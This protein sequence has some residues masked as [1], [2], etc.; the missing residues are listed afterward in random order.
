[1]KGQSAINVNPWSLLLAL[2]EAPCSVV[3]TDAGGRV[4]YVNERFVENSGYS[5][6]DV[7]GRKPG[8]VLR[9]GQTPP[10]TY[11][12]MWDT[13]KG[14]RVWH[15]D[16]YNRTKHGETRIERA[17]IIPMVENGCTSNYLSIQHD[18]GQFMADQQKLELYEALFQNT[19]IGILVTDHG[20]RILAINPAFTEITGYAQAEVQG[21]TPAML[22]SGMMPPEFYRSL[23]ASLSQTGSWAGEIINR[24]KNGEIYAE[25]LCINVVRDAEGDPLYHVA[26]L[27]DISERKHEEERLNQLVYHDVLTGLYNRKKLQDRVP[28]EVARARRNGGHFALMFLDLD[29]FKYINDTRGHNVGDK[30]LQEAATRISGQLRVSDFV[31][32]H[33]GDEFVLMLTDLDRPNAAAEV[34]IKLIHSLEKVYRIDGYELH[35]SCSI[36]IVLFPEDAEDASELLRKADMAMYRAKHKGGGRYQFYTK[37]IN[38]SVQHR[39]STELQLRRA[40]ERHEFTLNY[41]P[42]IDLASGKLISAEALLRW[43]HNGKTISP[44]DFIPIAE[45]TGLI[46]PIGEWVLDEVGRQCREWLDAGRVVPRIA[47]NLSTVQFHEPHLCLNIQTILDRHRFSPDL[48]EMEITESA[49]LGDSCTATC[50]IGELREMGLQVTLDDFGTGYSSLTYLRMFPLSKLK[51]DRSFVQNI[52]SNARDAAIIRT[53]IDLARAMSLKVVAEGVEQPGQ[54]D[55][56][57]SLG[58]HKGQG[59]L[60]SRPLEAAAFGRMLS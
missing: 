34:A 51:I 29:R 33:G 12:E 19:R 13:L 20:N 53:I 2:H 17:T 8:E 10:E 24:R 7:I 55:L 37:D 44:A 9:S 5:L 31:C 38:D 42:V 27:T 40:L 6:Q 52:A 59:Y 58:C 43:Q 3:L 47:V 28:E 4:E 35:L 23:W 25:W 46:L 1:M 36:G 30:L 15:G 56:L 14:G 49:A 16:L 26:A 39:Q 32:R 22:K 48:L 57:R 54:L 41:Q 11:Q 45:E 50:T 60:F 21:K 18:V